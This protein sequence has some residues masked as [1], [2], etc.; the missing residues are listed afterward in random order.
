MLLL[1]NKSNYANKKQIIK[2]KVKKMNIIV[3]LLGA[4]ALASIW[5]MFKY[6]KLVHLKALLD[7]AWSGID[8]QLKRRS[9]LIPNLVET[10]KGYST[11]EK[12]VFENVAKFRSAAIN[13][14]NIE[15]KINAEAGLS[16]ALRSLFAVAESY[17]ELKANQNFLSLQGELS[18]IENELQLAR[19]Y[20]NGTARNYNTVVRKFPDNI[21]ASLTGFKVAPY[22]EVTTTEERENPK[23]KF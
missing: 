4:L 22:F 1:Y 12:S 16:R 10:V 6:N 15:E 8:V 3:Y 23:V 18:S 17:P 19:R 14:R 13:S 20:Y 7:E 11:H 21:V 5:L 9:D 2:I